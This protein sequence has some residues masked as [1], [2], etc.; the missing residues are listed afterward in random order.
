MCECKDCTK[1]HLGCHSNCESYI[2][3]RKEQDEKNYKEF[4]KRKESQPTKR[5]LHRK[6]ILSTHMK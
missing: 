3:Y 4:L 2:Q 6:T 5:C 1:R